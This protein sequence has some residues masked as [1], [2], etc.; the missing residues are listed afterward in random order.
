[1]LKMEWGDQQMKQPN[2]QWIVKV[3]YKNPVNPSSCISS[4]QAT[5]V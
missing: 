5:A 4:T 2:D 3:D 1:M